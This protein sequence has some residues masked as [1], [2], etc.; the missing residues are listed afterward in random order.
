[1]PRSGE[2]P[3][4][5]CS[6]KSA[7]SGLR[8]GGEVMSSKNKCHQNGSSILHIVT[9]HFKLKIKLDF[10]MQEQKR[11]HHQQQQQQHGKQL[12]FK[13]LFALFAP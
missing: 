12:K 7:V 4:I 8:S 13:F 1:M 11:S 3:L 5:L 6:F 2:N 9:I 10:Q